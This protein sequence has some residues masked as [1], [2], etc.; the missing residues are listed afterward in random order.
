[1]TSPAFQLSAQLVGHESDVRAVAFPN[2]D[3]V[4]S[5]SRDCSV[6]LWQRTSDSSSSTSSTFEAH[7]TNQGSDYV[8]SI[9]YLPPTHAYP[10]G[11][12]VSGGR[13][14]IIDVRKPTSLPGDNAERLLIG[15]A[16][17]VCT[18]DV[19]PKGNYIVSGGWDSQAR[20]W[21][22]SKWETQF[23]LTGHELS[24]WAV[25]FLD[26]N[27]VVTGC[28]D[29]NIRIYDLRKAVSGD[30]QPR[31]TIYT[32]DIIRSLCAA[33]KNHVTG[34]DIVSA[35]NDGVL[36]FWKLNGQMVA[37]L[38][39]H[40]SFVY[41]LA[42]LPTGEIV[43]CAEDRTVRVWKD[44]ECVQTI[45]HPAIS[46]WCV[47]ACADSGDIVSGASDGVARV[48]T[49]SPE[50]VASP[51]AIAAFEESVKASAIPQQQVGG[52]NKEKLPGP[53]FLTTKS[54]T[55]EGQVQMIKEDNGSVSAYTW[56]TGM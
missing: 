1:M 21:S 37:E 53:E 8:N 51:D 41:G 52:I 36:R 44:L 10:E 15:H 55:K 33:P 38:R 54:G 17:N 35:S 7:I 29:K 28:A 26:E 23:M 14:T 3:A 18:L 46:V 6:R 34:A 32:D 4:L 22:V 56:S 19:S 2:P 43:S 50:R 5:A 42:A 40:E 39:G 30:V 24:V 16:H 25:T 31:S 11:L 48:F 12:V 47:A 49:R 20:V 27:T 45:T 9:T 13:D